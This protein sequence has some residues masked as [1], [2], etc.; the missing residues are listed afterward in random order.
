MFEKNIYNTQ[1]TKILPIRTIKDKKKSFKAKNLCQ[2]IYFTKERK[3]IVEKNTFKE[4]RADDKSYG[5]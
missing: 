1:Q 2:K 3:E 4:L 5:F